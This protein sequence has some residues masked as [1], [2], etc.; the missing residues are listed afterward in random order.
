MKVT[1][2]GAA[3]VDVEVDIEAIRADLLAR[4]DELE[5]LR[6]ASLTARDAV[7]LDQTRVGRLSRMDALQGQQMALA[8]ERHRLQEI[9]RIGAALKRID[10]GNYGLCL[11]CDEPL[12][13]SRL[14]SDPAATVCV[15]R[16]DGKDCPNL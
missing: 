7:E 9:N 10:A 12:P 13:A 15:A 14:H 1:P 5:S 11:A 8:T 6:A 2:W 3:K 4:R 16:A